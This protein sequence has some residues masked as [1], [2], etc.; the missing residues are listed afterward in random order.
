MVS[1]GRR[2]GGGFHV[3]ASSGPVCAPDAATLNPETASDQTTKFCNFRNSGFRAQPPFAI[4]NTCHVER[5]ARIE[6][7]ATSLPQTG[8]RSRRVRILA[9]SMHQKAELHASL[10]EA[11][12]AATLAHVAAALAHVHQRGRLA[13]AACRRR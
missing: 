2:S 5:R 12:V 3:R 10:L 8:T 4:I 13:F 1:Q 7:Y 9:D 6:T 11:A